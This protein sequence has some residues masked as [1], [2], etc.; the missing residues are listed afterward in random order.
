[1]GEEAADVPTCQVGQAAVALLVGEEGLAALPQ[2]LVAVH[3]RTVVGVQ[4]LG[5]E[6]GRLAELPGAVLD[7]VLELHEV[8]RR[9]L[10]RAEGVVDLL[11]ASRADFVVGPFDFQAHVGH[12]H[13][14]GVPQVAVL[15]VGGHREVAA[16]Q[17]GLV[18]E[19]APRLLAI[20]VPPSLVGVDGVERRVH[21]GVEAD[22][23]EDVELRFCA[24]VDGVGDARGA[25]VVLRLLRDV[26]GVAGVDLVG[27]GVD[28]G[29]VHDEGL[30]G[31][32]RIDEGGGD[33]GDELHVGLVDRL[34]PPDGRA[35]EHE[36]V[37]EDVVFEGVHRDG[38]MLHDAGQV[39]ESDVDEPD[40]PIPGER[41][42]FV[43]SGKHS[44][45]L[46]SS[47]SRLPRPTQGYRRRV[48]LE[49]PSRFRRVSAWWITCRAW[50]GDR[51]APCR[52]RSPW[53]WAGT[54]G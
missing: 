28:D 30:L 42:G 37:G 43:G 1:M 5:H 4:R 52:G 16:L 7:D 34:E 49:G 20:G 13:A 12:A 22:V 24:E 44:Y 25:H 39:A 47:A 32:E 41:D 40:V 23:V 53:G 19:V 51:G 18:A 15:V 2:G 26:A 17:A 14:H 10:E 33:V 36:A 21:V 3:A 46:P 35:V 31:P 48:S 8:V 6:S 45:S 50:P 54:S 38:E 27:E 9:R 29:E 11:L